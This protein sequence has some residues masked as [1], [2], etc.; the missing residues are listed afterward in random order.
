M[1]SLYVGDLAPDVT[2]A[3]LYEKFSPAGPI[4]SVR[5]CKD[6]ITKRSLGYAYINFENSRDAE[7]AL[8]TINFETINNKPIRIM[9]SQRD[10]AMRKS[11]VGN[12]FIKNLDKSIDNKVMYDTFSPF[13]N[14]L[15]CKVAQDEDGN[16]RGC[17]FV[18]FESEESAINAINKVNGMLLNGKKVY[19][20][21]FIS[22]KDRDQAI[23]EKPKEFTNVYIKNLT[24]EM[25]DDEKLKKYFEQYGSVISARV[26]MDENGKSR[27]FGFVN[28]EKPE[29]AEKAVEDLNGKELVKGKPLFVGRAQ[30][31]AE[32]QA[33]LK[34]R[35]E[36]IRQERVNRNRGV[37]LYV[38]NLDDSITDQK[39]REVFASY[40][41]ITSAKVMTDS[42]GRGKGFGFVC[43]AQADQA[44][45]AVTELSN[46]I[47]C[48]KPLYV[49]IAQRKDERKMHLEIQHMERGGTA[50][51]R[52]Q[53]PA[54][55][56]HHSLHHPN[57]QAAQ[58]YGANPVAFSAINMGNQ[59]PQ[60]NQP[61]Q[62]NFFTPIM[63]GAHQMQQRG[64]YAQP[65]V[66][67]G[68]N[69]Q[70]AVKSR[71]PNN[72]QMNRPAQANHLPSRVRQNQGVPNPRQVPGV[73]MNVTRPITGSLAPNPYATRGAPGPVQLGR[74]PAVGPTGQI[75]GL[76]TK[77]NQMRKLSNQMPQGQVAA[78]GGSQQVPVQQ[79]I[80]IEGQPPLT[81][82]MLAEADS[83]NQKQMLGERIFPLIHNIYPEL[84]PKITGMLLEI[85]NSEL[86][87]MLEHQESLKAKADEALAVLQA[88]QAKEL[89]AHKKE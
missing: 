67:P 17:G 16:S 52:G 27:G 24:E 3:D 72:S 85:D 49:A 60:G 58:M 23:D 87:H 31:K 40:G 34:R 10:P 78:A 59:G 80:Q 22:R 50:N 66:Y 2:E 62:S 30:K 29:E 65:S 12:I 45:K 46:R 81:T 8:D 88:H 33:E 11:G 83:H 69:P 28:F 89:A 43:F 1:A 57:L 39:L 37:N 47:V 42:T 19:V 86:L 35:F 75:A 44:T 7:T 4:I 20:G 36:Q 41:E 79:S 32:R 6:L 55:H 21:H 38:K 13:G 70:I 53:P 15:S 77:Y 76:N 25:D 14:I 84:A 68:Q 26:M 64:F 56:Q 61:G 63:Q 71:W 82:N 48:G 5:V 54:P 73:P 51:Y 18:H 74:A 9:W